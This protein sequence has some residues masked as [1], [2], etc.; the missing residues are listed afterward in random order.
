RGGGM[1]TFPPQSAS[2]VLFD[3]LLGLT[4]PRSVMVIG[5]S[6]RAGTLGH[7]TVLNLLEHSEF[8]GEVFLVNPKGGRWQQRP[9]YQSVSDVPA[10]SIDVAL[11]LVPAD[12]A[13]A[14]LQACV[15]KGVRYAIVFTG[16]F[17]ELGEQGRMA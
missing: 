11:L 9:L 15:A 17:A 4:Q 10:Q 6:T 3:D 16:G 13:Y 1:S 2:G 12:A 5:A 14:T 7:T 8:D